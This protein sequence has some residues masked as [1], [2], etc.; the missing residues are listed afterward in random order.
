[1]KQETMIVVG[2]GMVG[3]RFCER[4]C[5]LDR[6]HRYRVILLGEE[7]YGPYDRVNLASYYQLRDPNQLLLGAADFYKERGIDLR[8]AQRATLLDTRA[9]TVTTACGQHYHYDHLV[10][11]TGSTPFMPALPGIDKPG[12]FAY[13]TLD[14][15]KCIE[16]YARGQRSVAVL[17]G[18]LLG[19]EAARAL[20]ALGLKTHVIELAPRLMPRQLDDAGARLLRKSIEALGI[21]TH[22]GMAT[23]EVLGADSCTGIAFT[24]G[25]TLAVNMLVVSAGIRARDELARTAGIMVGDRGGVV[26]DDGLSTSEP[27]V[28][29]VGE[30][31]LHRGVT[32]GLVVPGYE[33]ADVLARRLLG[34]EAS[35]TGADQSVKLKL[36]GVDVAMFGDPF[37]Q[38]EPTKEIVLHDLVN[39]IYKKL[40]VSDDARRLL[41]GMLVGDASDYQTLLALLRARKELPMPLEELILGK[42]G[43]AASAPIDDSAQICAC[44]NVSRGDVC[45]KIR[46]GVVTLAGIR[47]STR[48]GTG[49]GGCVPLVTDLLNA[50]LRAAGQSVSRQ[51]CEHFAFTRQEL[52]E[53]VAV[54]GYRSFEEII[55]KVGR[56]SGCEACK[57]LLASI[58]ASVHNDLILNHETVQDTND[59]FLAN[60]QRGGLYSVVPRIPGGEITPE[61]LIKLGEVAR[62]YRL[63]TKITGG[64]RIDLFGAQLNQLPDI[65]EELVDAGFES[66]HAYGK[67]VRTVKSCVGSTWCRYGVQDSVAFAIRVEERY[68]GIRAP[69]K[70]KSAVSGCIREC[71]EAQSKDFGIIATEKGWNLYVCG[72]GGTKPRHADLLA[73]DL[74]SETCLRYIDR[75]LMFYIRTADKLTRTSVWLEKMEGGI[76][77]LRDVIVNDS[78]NLCAEL[79]RDMRK[80]VDS[81]QCEWAQVV[82]DPERRGRFQHFANSPEPDTTVRFVE[83]RDQKRPADWPKRVRASSTL[84]LRLP[85]VH[86]RWVPLVDALAVPRDGGIAVKYGNVQLAVFNFASRGAWYATQNMCPHKQDM[87]LSRGI[88]GDEKGQPKV[89]CPLHKKTF[90]LDSGEC[91]SGDPYRIGTFAVQVNRGMVYVELP[92]VDV[93]E[94]HL[95]KSSG[96]CDVIEAAE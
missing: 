24:D 77:H 6:Q 30:V 54:R 76:T 8:V 50:Q 40:V 15:L 71:A 87:V 3:H 89:A 9:Q 96:A 17:G 55:E 72:N 70:L 84:K 23:R 59:R 91:L 41:G 78:L 42:R 35:F 5:E 85:T 4:L 44:N 57:P 79:E 38:R 1:M 49:C 37:T 73:A 83:E 95:C 7:P 45:A 26:V 27:G 53:I 43:T 88:I 86:R 31:A 28:Y 2:A 80:L 60:M 25:T 92:P 47:T 11:A 20:S 13:R 67:A 51:V 63:Y 82:K 62:K 52:F 22:L 56:G 68:K 33:M 32:Y 34:Q 64:Q 93:L 48:A 36:L 81:Y 66:G 21:E 94:A 10:L 65:W 58:L 39:G 19:L 75:F 74:D 16:A 61:K 46:A 69:H 14:D 18:G 90:A 12:V 29:A